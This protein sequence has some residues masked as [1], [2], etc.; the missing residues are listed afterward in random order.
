MLRGS[1]VCARLGIGV[2]C[3][4]LAACADEDEVP[5]A[6][7]P[8]GG[9]AGETGLPEDT[10]ADTDDG[11]SDDAPG[12]P[13]VCDP[14]DTA[15]CL[16]PDGVTFGEH[17]CRADGSGWGGCDCG[18]GATGPDG[19]GDDDGDGDDNGDGGEVETDPEVCY[20]GENNAWTTCV[21]IHT[22]D[23]PPTGYS[24]P[25]PL[26]GNPNYRKPVAFIDLEQIDPK[27]KLAP[28]FTLDEIAQ[29][30][31]GRWAIVQP[32]AVESL[33]KLRDAVG[34]I[35]VNSGYRS[36]QYN[37]QV[38][39]ATHSRHMYGDAFDMAPQ[40]VSLATLENQCVSAGGQLV[41]YNSHVH[42]DFRFDDVS[43]EFFG[44]APN[45]APLPFDELSGRIVSIGDVHTAPAE[46]FDEGEPFREWTARDADGVVLAKGEG[47]VF[48][49]PR[50]TATVEVLIGG[51]IEVARSLQAE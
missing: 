40:S 12:V 19:G 48:V 16:C 30:F 20:P 47:N 35:G 18:G 8:P 5:G 10:E 11:A 6:W 24:Y 26:Q 49:A 2:S 44:P 25:D 33:Q 14:G 43:V 32:H 51:R 9:E 3:L 41:K 42:C 38:G 34:A 23:S 21:P 36:P 15:S 13:G 29:S 28:N 22:F 7:N 46:G 31:K 50:G 39:G 1:W 37:S 27:L 4:V 45:G 17:A